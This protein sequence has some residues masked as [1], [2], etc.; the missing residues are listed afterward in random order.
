MFHIDW[1]PAHFVRLI[2]PGEDLRR[3]DINAESAGLAVVFDEVNIPDSGVLSNLCLLSLKEGHRLPSSSRYKGV[4]GAMVLAETDERRFVLV[5]EQGATNLMSLAHAPGRARFTLATNA[6]T[7]PSTQERVRTYQASSCL[8]VIV[9]LGV[10]FCF[11]RLEINWHR[12]LVFASW[13]SEIA[14][15]PAQHGGQSFELIKGY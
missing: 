2:P 9:T 3:A 13:P 12:S 5:I 1:T 11:L 4:G 14:I 7:R 15:N 8:A 10:L 6:F